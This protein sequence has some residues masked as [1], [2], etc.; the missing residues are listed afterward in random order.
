MPVSLFSCKFHIHK[1][2]LT[3]GKPNFTVF[4]EIKMCIDDVKIKKKQHLTL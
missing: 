4:E 3:N 1:C 2:K